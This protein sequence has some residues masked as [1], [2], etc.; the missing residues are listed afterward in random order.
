MG[1]PI[2]EGKPASHDGIGL[3]MVMELLQL[4]NGNM[5]VSPNNGYGTVV[6]ITLTVIR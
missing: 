6:D 1:V 5:R 3:I 2:M 4:I